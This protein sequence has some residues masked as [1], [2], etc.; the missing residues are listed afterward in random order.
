MKKK[1]MEA[2]NLT[3]NVKMDQESA[4]K[5]FEEGAVFVLLDVPV[6]T[7]FGM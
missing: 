5:L 1:A 6:G 7:E 2:S 4:L 3:E